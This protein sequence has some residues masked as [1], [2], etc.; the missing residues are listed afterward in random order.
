MSEG[1]P[2]L[3][4]PRSTA[5]LVAAYNAGVSIRVL[6]EQTGWTYSWIRR[7][8]L[9]E[10]V[11]LRGRPPKRPCS[12]PVAQLAQEYA[13][14]ASILTLAKRHG[15]YFKRVREL[16]LSHGVTLRPSTKAGRDGRT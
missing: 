5:Y 4:E 1:N 11:E 12:V 10:G 8:L 15:L 2:S 14:G 7:Q 6:E 13:D 16:L 9:A 3:L